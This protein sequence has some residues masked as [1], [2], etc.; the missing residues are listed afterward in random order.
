M[1]P[2]GSSAETLASR[3][4]RQPAPPAVCWGRMDRASVCLGR[5][6]PPGATASRFR[7]D[8][9][10]DG[11][12]GLRL[13]GNGRATTRGA[14]RLAETRASPQTQKSDREC[15]SSDHCNSVVKLLGFDLGENPSGVTLYP[16]SPEAGSPPL[17]GG[18]RGGAPFRP[19][20]VGLR[21]LLTSASVSLASRS[22]VAWSWCAQ[23]SIHNPA[24]S[25]SSSAQ[26][27]TYSSTSARVLLS[28]SIRSTVLWQSLRS[29]TTP[30][31]GWRGSPT[32]QA[33]FLR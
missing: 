18:R 10:A 7:S 3:R 4:E 14:G 6:P 26:C 5:T 1:R 33:S 30:P 21:I 29:D 2:L 32:V 16:M 27:S 24:F 8:S 28:V 20:F 11:G 25:I 23:A 9:L 15:C 13:W 22:C 19:D 17:P 31:L 12:A